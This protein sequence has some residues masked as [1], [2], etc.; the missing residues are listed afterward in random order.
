MVRDIQS[1][2]GVYSWEQFWD[3][4]WKFLALELEAG[5]FDYDLDERC[6]L[7]IKLRRGYNKGAFGDV[8]EG[9]LNP[10]HAI[11]SER[12]SRVVSMMLILADY[13]NP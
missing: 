13:G 7:P 4:Q 8:R 9:E 3:H 1:K 2:W 6:I 10:D 5:K 12:V 11:E